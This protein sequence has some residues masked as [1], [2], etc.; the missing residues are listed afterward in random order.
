MISKLD[1]I[2][3]GTIIVMNWRPVRDV[4][5]EFFSNLFVKLDELDINNFGKSEV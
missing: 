2:H 1:F 5:S 4:V 3:T